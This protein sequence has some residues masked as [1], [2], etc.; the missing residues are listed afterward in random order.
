VKRYQIKPFLRIFIAVKSRKSVGDAPIDVEKI[1][2][3]G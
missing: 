1:Q 3:I 2:L